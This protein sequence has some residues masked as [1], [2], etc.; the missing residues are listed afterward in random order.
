[1]QGSYT[2]RIAHS[3]DKKWEPHVYI[4]K[5]VPWHTFFTCFTK[6]KCNLPQC[7]GKTTDELVFKGTW[8]RYWSNFNFLFLLLTMLYQC[9]SNKRPK[10]DISWR[11]MNQNT[12]LIIL[13][14]ICKQGKCHVL[15]TLVQCTGKNS[16][17]YLLIRF[18]HK[19]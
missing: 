8:S 13:C 6:V 5:V 2:Q 11:G 19:L 9:I 15:F 3:K 12:Q 10:F 4:W 18:E 14:Y 1:M 17:L 16:F 7:N